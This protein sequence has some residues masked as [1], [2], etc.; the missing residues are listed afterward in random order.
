MKLNIDTTGTEVHGGGETIAY[1]F[2]ANK[3]AFNAFSSKLYSDKVRAVIRELACNAWDAHMAAG[4]GDEP[5]EIH[6]PTTHEPWFSINDHGTGLSHEDMVNLFSSYFGS[7]KTNRNDQ[8]GA[9]GLGSKSPFCYKGNGGSYSIISRK[10][11]VTRAYVADMTDGLPGLTPFSAVDTPGAPDGIEVKFAVKTE[12]VWEWGNK[13]RIALEMFDPQPI[14]NL[15][16]PMPP[17]PMRS[18]VFYTLKSPTGSWGLRKEAQTPQGTGARAIMG[19]VQYQIGYID[20]SKMNTAH[21][22]TAELPLD[23]YFPLGGL[24]FAISRESLEM[25]DRTIRTII[26]A[27]EDVYA[28]MVASVKARIDGCRTPWEARMMLY[29]LIYDRKG[30]KTKVGH[31]VAGA[32]DGGDLYGTYAN[33]NFTDKA[34]RIVETDYLHTGVAVFKHN[35][36]AAGRGRK[37]QLFQ[38]DRAKRAFV[39]AELAAGRVPKGMAGHVVEATPEV[40]FVVNDLKTAGDKYV[41]WLLQSADDNKNS[42]RPVKTVYVVYRAK[43]AH[44]ADMLAEAEKLLAQ[45]G[46]PAALRMS[47]LKARYSYIDAP[48]AARYR[49][50]QDRRGILALKDGIG[51]RYRYNST[52]WGKAWERSD[53]QPAGTKY[54]VVLDNLAPAQSPWP[55]AWGFETFV[56]HVRSSGRFGMDARTPVYGLRKD[57]KMIGAPGWVEFVGHVLETVK[58]TMTPA[59]ELQLSLHLEPFADDYEGFLRRVA[60]DGSLM[61]C[62]GPVKRFADELAAA[63]AHQEPRWDSFRRVLDFAASRGAWKQGKTVNFNKRWAGVKAQYPLLLHGTGYWRGDATKALAEYV[64]LVDDARRAKYA[65]MAAS[66]ISMPLS[67][68]N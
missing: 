27:Y 23:L 9:L 28:D 30:E 21:R 5:F 47:E 61:P 19:N 8:I 12:D 48:A 14:I 34:P 4:R 42:E 43:N 16:P 64:G 35:A 55:D 66:Q 62:G 1:S 40:L 37:D 63:K 45:A 57:S 54:Y 10:D 24:D 41:H 22:Q 59:K 2:I 56:G 36:R 46:N 38:M 50:P 25:E 6:L 53:E 32:L 49:V 29:D 44:T 11:G 67:A 65:A 17:C 31:I 26:K 52:G 20:T 39:L 13:A 18:E 58:A 51:R 7:N 15:S 3:A 68:A 60:E 33:F